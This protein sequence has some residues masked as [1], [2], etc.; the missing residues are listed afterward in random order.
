[1]HRLSYILLTPIWEIS[2]SLF[3][4]KTQQK[5]NT[6]KAKLRLQG[7]A[8]IAKSDWNGWHLIRCVHSAPAVGRR[9]RK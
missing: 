4:V 9:E 5:L 6:E 2:I 1:M 3:S 8:V 7:N